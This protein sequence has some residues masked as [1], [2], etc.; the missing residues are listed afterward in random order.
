[1]S[2]KLSADCVTKS[3]LYFLPKCALLGLGGAGTLYYC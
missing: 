1:M 2:L 3:C